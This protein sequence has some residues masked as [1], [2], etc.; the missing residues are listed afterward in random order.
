MT[1]DSN[2]FYDDVPVGQMVEEFENWLFDT[3]RV[4]GEI[5]YP[6]PIKTPYGYH[7]MLYR[8]NEV[9]AWKSEIKN[10]IAGESQTA[11]LE[12]LQ[13]TYPVELRSKNL[14]FIVGG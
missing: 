13:E 2:V 12:G 3:A 8:G 10:T 4:E 7:I 9:E 14:R 11:Y 6:E 5:S 1:E